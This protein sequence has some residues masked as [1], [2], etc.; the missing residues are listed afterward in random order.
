MHHLF[1]TLL[2]RAHSMSKGTTGSG[3]RASLPP[4]GALVVSFL[5]AYGAIS[6]V[7]RP[8]Q[9]GIHLWNDVL[10]SHGYRE[11]KGAVPLLDLE[12]GPDDTQASPD[13]RWV[14]IPIDPQFPNLHSVFCIDC[15]R[16]PNNWQSIGHSWAALTQL[17]I[18]LQTHPLPS[19][20]RVRPSAFQDLR[21]ILY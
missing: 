7:E 12:A 8:G 18:E 6:Q 1:T 3:Q 9:P 10:K 5:L 11:W 2:S 4:W 16:L 13:R 15:K 19:P 20:Q 14:Y 21:E 17:S